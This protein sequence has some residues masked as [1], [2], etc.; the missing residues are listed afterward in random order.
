MAPPR[1]RRP[2]F[3]RRVQFSLF[4]GYV[5]AI[6]GIVG[7]LMLIFLS[8]VDP[9]GFGRLRGAAIDAGAPVSKAG[10]Q[11][12]RGAGSLEEQVQAYFFAARQNQ[13]LRE[14]LAV[15][16]RKLI[17]TQALRLENAKLRRTLKLTEEARATVAVARLI[18]SD[19]TS[20]RRFA[21]L[22]A[23]TRQGVQPGQPVI[24]AD[25]LVGRILEAGATASRVLLLTDGESTVPVRLA[26]DGTPALIRGRGDGTLSI[27]SLMPG[28]SPFKRGDVV[29][30]SGTG[31]IYPPSVPVAVI[32]QVDGDSAVAWPLASPDS[33]DF[34]TVQELYQPDV[35]PLP[36]TTR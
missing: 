1:N 36:G 7:A 24:A 16:R 9:T 21:T 11:V 31:G 5:I 35:P 33:L 12:V 20:A 26:R 29:L 27:R 34:A 15:A 32:T 2:G 30:T 14:E 22:S 13:A 3:S 19:F 17:E 8:R 6:V 25:G 28:A 4:I 18:G 10:R 23:G